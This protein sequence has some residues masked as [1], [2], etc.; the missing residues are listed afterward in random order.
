MPLNDLVAFK[1]ASPAAVVTAGSASV[2]RTAATWSAATAA[3][4]E[5]SPPRVIAYRAAADPA[6]TIVGGGDVV[7]AAYSGADRAEAYCFAPD[8]NGPDE[9]GLRLGPGLRWV[10]ASPTL[11]YPTDPV[12]CVLLS[13]RTDQNASAGPPPPGTR[14]L[15]PR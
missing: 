12:G 4:W 6:F 1:R 10:P 15:T 2:S 7:L 5:L 3:L 9:R 14:R 8:D 11:S 13:A